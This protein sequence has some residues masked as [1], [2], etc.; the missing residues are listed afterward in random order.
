MSRMGQKMTDNP[1][2]HNK[3]LH[4]LSA[5]RQITRVNYTSLLSKVKTESDV[6]EIQV[7]ETCIIIGWQFIK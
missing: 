3:Q 5:A 1:D 4:I 6:N 2:K 7:M